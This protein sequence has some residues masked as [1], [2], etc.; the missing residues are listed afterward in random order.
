LGLVYNGFTDIFYS[1]TRSGHK[2]ELNLTLAKLVLDITSKKVSIIPSSIGNIFKGSIFV[3]YVDEQLIEYIYNKFETCKYHELFVFHEQL[4][5]GERSED[6][7]DDEDN[8]NCKGVVT[9]YEY[10][11]NH[12]G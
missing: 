6:L 1:D 5:M 2:L 7:K 11:R 9:K 8:P 4:P 12:K 3:N 10:D